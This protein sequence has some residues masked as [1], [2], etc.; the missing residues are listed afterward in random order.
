[1]GKLVANQI[2]IVSSL[3]SSGSMARIICNYILESI[4]QLA[5]ASLKSCSLRSNAHAASLLGS[6]P[7]LY[8]SQFLSSNV[9]NKKSSKVQKNSPLS[10]FPCSKRG[11]EAS[12]GRS[13]HSASLWLN[14]D[15]VEENAQHGFPSV[16]ALAMSGAGCQLG[17]W[18]G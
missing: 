7:V 9:S 16:L 15:H 4:R 3:L 8:F 6:C 17:P 18:L 14:C 1:M 12:T 13:T 10:I 5:Q 11:W 2:K